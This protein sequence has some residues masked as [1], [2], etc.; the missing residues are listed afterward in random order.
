MAFPSVLQ[1]ST[2]QKDDANANTFEMTRPAGLTNGN[3][4][5]ILFAVDGDHAITVTADGL[6]SQGTI[7]E[8]SVSLVSCWLKIDGTEPTT[9]TMTI[10]SGTERACGIAYEI[11]D[12]ADPGVDS[13]GAT[14]TTGSSNTP[15]PP[16]STPAGGAKDF[17]WIAAVGVD[18]NSTIDSFP[19]NMTVGSVQLNV[20]GGGA[21]SCSIGSD[22]H[23]LNATSFNPNTFGIS[24]SDGWS[25]LTI[26]IFP[27]DTGDTPMV[28][29]QGSYSYTGQASDLLWD[30]DLAGGAVQGSYDLTGKAAI[31]SRGFL[32]TADQGS[33]SLAGQAALFLRTHVLAA[34]QGD[35]TYTGQ[36]ANLLWDHLIDA[37]Q[38]SYG[39]TG[40]A[41]EFL[42]GATVVAAQGG[43]SLT[44]QAANLLWDHIITAVQGSY[45][46]T[47]FAAETRKGSTLI[48]IQGAYSLAG[49]A[50]NLLFNPLIAA[51]QG[52]YTLT[53]QAAILTKNIPLIAVQGSYN[54]TGQAAILTRKVTIIAA[55]GSYSLT[56]QAANLLWGHLMAA[57]QGNYA[58]TGFAAIT[59]KGAAATLTA[60]QGSYILT[61]K[62][63]ILTDSGAVGGGFVPVIRPRRR[64]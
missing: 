62:D 16:N 59:S 9:F 34:V 18:R 42:L 27:A 17:L 49:Q 26:N 35:Y 10:A 8:G 24:A 31:T 28:A 23:Q 36:A 15:D 39:L 52:S 55:Q 14:N 53:G 30:H 12:A 64:R 5:F 11:Q 46:Y 22:T 37:V 1:S 57:A 51:L 21:N 38:G 44:G 63:A 29:A 4:L 6:T 45:A 50:A 3:T 13:P 61:G 33:Y 2:F 60:V 54:L 41:A 48:A 19:T 58:Y 43:Y 25:G 47:G 56:G 40:Q 20:D 32:T 7:R